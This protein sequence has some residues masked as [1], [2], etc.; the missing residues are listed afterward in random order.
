MTWLRRLLEPAGTS[1]P[2]DLLLRLTLVDLMFR[3][4]TTSFVRPVTLAI[5]AL[6]LLSPRV[7]RAPVAWL[8]LAGAT[9]SRVVADWPLAD[10]HAYLLSYWCLSVAIALLLPEGAG[11]LR[12]SGRWLMAMAFLFTILWKGFLAPDYLDGRF[13]RVTLLVDERFAY[14]SQ[15]FGGLTS[16]ELKANREALKPLPGGVEPLEPAELIETPAFR[17]FAGFATWWTIGIEA[18]I[19]LA[20]LLPLRGRG[21]AARHVLLMIFCAATYAFAPVAGFGWLLLVMGMSQCEEGD[22]RWRLAYAVTFFLVLFIVEIPWARHL[23]Q[24]TSPPAGTS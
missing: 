16:E 9:G 20:F 21:R 18:A 8:A 7:L 6:G 10:N 19:A 13:F 12:I 3:P 14:A 17:R 5:A 23:V 1:P 24:L 22:R 11:A 15:L 4:G 2:A